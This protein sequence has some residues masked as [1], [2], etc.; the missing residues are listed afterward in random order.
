M[1]ADDVMDLY[2]EPE[3]E[4]LAITQPEPLELTPEEVFEQ[5]QTIQRLMRSVMKR[6][7]HYDTIRGCGPKP[8]LLKAGAEK[9]MLTF[10]L[11]PAYTVEL[12]TLEEGHFNAQVHTTLTHIPT[13]RVVAQGLGSCAT[14]ETKYRKNRPADIRNTVLKMAKKRSMVDAVL[15]ATAASDIFTQ[16]LEDMNIGNCEPPP[17]EQG[18][19]DGVLTEIRNATSAD[20]LRAIAMRL[21]H[22]PENQRQTFREEWAEKM[23]EVI[24][25]D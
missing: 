7:T 4:D 13:G 24:G 2:P 6:G 14:D 22:L 5:V 11:A 18:V 23:K 21:R 17:M 10:R 8:V 20:E 25:N 15:A 12:T 19:A 1:S 9:L 16:D 3:P